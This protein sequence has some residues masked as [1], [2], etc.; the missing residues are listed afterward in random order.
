MSVIGYLDKERGR[1]SLAEKKLRVA[2]NRLI[3]LRGEGTTFQG[4][5]KM[6]S[7]R[8][9]TES[10]TRNMQDWRGV[11]PVGTIEIHVG[12]CPYLGKKLDDEGYS[13]E[14]HKRR[15]PERGGTTV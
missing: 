10:G 15:T 8:S 4:E 2:E 6:I 1:G 11:G 13:R 5:K 7:A 14:G 12:D 9:A 3:I